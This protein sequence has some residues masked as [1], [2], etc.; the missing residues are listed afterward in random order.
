[1]NWK[2]SARPPS[3]PSARKPAMLTATFTAM[4]AI[5]TAMAEPPGSP[6][7]PDAI[8][9]GAQPFAL[10]GLGAG[11]FHGFFDPGRESRE[12][13]RLHVLGRS[14]CEDLRPVG[15]NGM[16]HGELPHEVWQKG[17]TDQDLDA[18]PDRVRHREGEPAAAPPE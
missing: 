18:Q 7:I 12:G 6:G 3:P 8:E 1:M 13:L 9:I 4:R 16:G 10:P 2:R 5:S 11:L 14:G 15:G 17:R